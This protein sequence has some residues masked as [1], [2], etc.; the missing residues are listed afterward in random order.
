MLITAQ[1]L[2]KTMGAK[3]LFTDLELHISPG[4]KVALIGRNGQGKSTLLNI[5]GGLDH[6]FSGDIVRQK[7]LRTVLTKQEHLTD[8]TQTAMEYIL[9]SVPHYAKYE[10]IL[11]DFEEGRHEDMHLYSEAVDYFSEHGYYYIK[12]LIVGTLTDFQISE[13]EANQPLITLS[14]GE[15]RFVELVRMMYSQA[16]LLLIDEPTNHMDYVGKGQFISWMHTVEAGLLI[17]THDRDVLQNVDRIIELKDKTIHSFKGNY[18]AYLKQNTMKTTSSVVQYQ[19]QMKKLVEAKKK[20]EWGLAMR[21][22]S[23]AWKV[24]YDHWLKDYEKIKEETVKPSF[25]IDQDSVQDLDQNVSDSYEKFKEKNVRIAIPTNNDRIS[26][27]LAVRGLS[28]GYTSPLFSDITFTVGHKRH[29]FIKGRN[30]AGKSTLVKTI[31]SQYN[32]TAP[33]AT[34]YD[35]TIKLVSGLRIGEYNQEI[36]P[37]YLPQTLEGAIYA[38]YESFNIPIDIGKAKSTMS[39]Y[40]FDPVVD[41]RQKI[42]DLSGGQKARFQLIKM[43]ANKP[44]LLILDE[45]TNHLD[46]PSIEE[47]EN[48]LQD[49]DGGI[50]YISH[51]TNFINKLGG[52]VIEL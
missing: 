36:D 14:G 4:E 25:W 43:F 15:K 24:R 42:A 27:L 37:K 2:S 12:D 31:I 3:T 45:P 28:I 33:H 13:T 39:Q 34:V 11:A 16:E 48:A 19:N 22:K 52:D 23:K 49:Y 9:K 6:E 17:V 35:G 21:A 30:G 50:L 38:V 10:K 18:D 8:N 44:N 7:N 5:I 32:E 26:Q 41:A 46:L 1:H 51:D 40:L 20:V 29:V 47:L